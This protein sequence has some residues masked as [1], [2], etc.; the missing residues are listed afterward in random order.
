MK[1]SLMKR[2]RVNMS[3]NKSYLLAQCV[4]YLLCYKKSLIYLGNGH[5]FKHKTH[6]FFIYILLTTL[7]NNFMQ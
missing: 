5:K 6:L 7:Q 3:R 1:R 4:M 2:K